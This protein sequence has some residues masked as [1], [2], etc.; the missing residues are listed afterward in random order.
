MRNKTMFE[1]IREFAYGL[2]LGARHSVDTRH[3]MIERA[4]RPSVSAARKNTF[5]ASEKVGR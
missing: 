2:K 5:V 4:V 3:N 1:M